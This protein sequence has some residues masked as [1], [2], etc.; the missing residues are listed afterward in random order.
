MEINPRAGKA[1]YYHSLDLTKNAD[2]SANKLRS[3]YDGNLREKP[4]DPKDR[5]IANL[6]AEVDRLKKPEK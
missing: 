3:F 4:Q 2:Q 1:F 6:R 5:E